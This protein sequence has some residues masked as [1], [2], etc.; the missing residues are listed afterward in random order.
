VIADRPGMAGLL[1]GSGLPDPDGPVGDGASFGIESPLAPGRLWNL[2]RRDTL[3]GGGALLLGLS[4]PGM[5]A[6]APP[7]EIALG[8][9]SEAA[10]TLNAWVR[11]DRKGIV[12]I[13][14]GASEMGQGV[15]TA[16]PMLVAEELDADWESVRVEA[17][18]AD[19]PYRRDSIAF[20]GRIQ[21]TGGSESVRGYWTI[22]RDAGASARD[23]LVRAAASR[24]KVDPAACRTE[25]SRVL[26]GESVL[27][28]GELVDDAARLSPP[29]KV[30][31]KEPS[32]WKLLGTSPPRTDV[33][34]KVNGTAIFGIDVRLPGM[35]NATVRAC[36]HYGGKLASFDDTAARAMKGV[37]EVF[38]IDDVIVCVADTFFHAK[39]AIGAVQATWDAGKGKG[40]DDAAVQ[41]ALEKALEAGKKRFA[42][43]EKPGNF[44]VDATYSVPFL[45]HA[46]LEPLNA[47]AWV[48]ADRVDVWI[49]TQAQARV[50]RRAARI[51]G[52]NQA[53]V[54]IHTTL[55][56]GGFGR[57]GF[58]DFGDYA[59]KIAM[60]YDKPVKTLWTREESFTH[61][62]HRPATLCR[63]RAAL[64]PDGLPSDWHVQ[65]SAQS[66]LQQYLPEALLGIPLA[67]ETTIGGMSH[68]PYAIPNQQVDYGRV[69]LPIPVG[70]WRSVHGSHNGFFRECFLDELAHE[71]KRDPIE[72]RRALLDSPR[73]KAVFEL[74]VANAGP[75]P[76]GLSRGVAVFESFGSWVAEVLDLE[77]KDG[78]VY[79]R[80]IVA[81]VDCG[82]VVH[83]EIV[84][85]QVAGAATM[86][87]SAALFGRLSFEDGAVR[88]QNFHQYPLLAMKQAPRIEVYLVPSNEPPG[89]VGE[90]GL[91]PV[92][93][94]LCNAIFAATGKRIRQL[95]VGNQLKA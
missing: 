40:L 38:A 30:V 76:A 34:A 44:T 62:F 8:P 10:T 58:D 13:C 81:A 47:T 82:V 57:R 33:P 55:L 70:W 66:I 79:V 46:P 7:A 42:K 85:A 18:P 60:R 43:G 6:V 45:E 63:Q 84:K 95:P 74:A 78:D 37:V 41:A 29:K 16:L 23:M 2:S 4:L 49:G 50:K 26:H 90:V 14:M 5:A 22:L 83:P 92:A 24:W 36:P 94:A 64:G 59:V 17:A 68:A 1:R 87:L 53:D 88:E 51:T 80:R 19:V 54:F 11:V 93:G 12:T 25:K 77:V 61:G 48:Q 52:R 67:V 20:P 72:Y 86:G 56:G 39:K 89:G 91:P 15:F 35:L 75:V 31:W 69:E 28:Y 73:D 3:R 9:A 21:L 71:A 65:M 27:T 32:Q